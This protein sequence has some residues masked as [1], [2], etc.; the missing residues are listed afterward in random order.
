[1]ETSR[2]ILGCAL[3]FASAAAWADN[4]EVAREAYTEGT[5]LYDIA[6]FNGALTAFKKAYVNYE[7]PSFLF[8]IAQCYRQVGNK[9]EALRFYRTYLRKSASAP[10]GDEVRKLIATLE[11]SLA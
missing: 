9:P 8:N 2:L 1:M 10:N 6:D 4:K 5:R 3:F 11:A 7:E